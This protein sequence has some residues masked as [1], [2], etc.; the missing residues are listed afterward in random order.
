V[1]VRLGPGAILSGVIG[2]GGNGF[3]TCDVTRVSSRLG[4]FTCDVSSVPIPPPLL[5]S[6]FES[7][8]WKLLYE[9]SRST[10]LGEFI[11][12]EH[13]TRRLL[14]HSNDGEAQSGQGGKERWMCRTRVG[15]QEFAP[16]FRP[17]D[18]GMAHSDIGK[19]WLK[20]LFLLTLLLLLFLKMYSTDF[21]ASRPPFRAT[22]RLLRHNV[23]GSCH[24]SHLRPSSMQLILE[25][26]KREVLR[27]TK[28]FRTTR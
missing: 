6:G 2:V 10:N 24:S 11:D 28:E 1:N 8:F 20:L 3:F 22:S 19:Q 18:H 16:I 13:C 12:N 9:C 5:L 7:R 23:H 17:S 15:E 4:L 21:L 27:N 25:R 14:R 26:N